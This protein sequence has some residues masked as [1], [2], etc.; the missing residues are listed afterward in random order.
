MKRI[1]K[2]FT[3]LVLVIVLG[4]LTAVVVVRLTVTRE[5]VIVPDLIG[6][7]LVAALDSLE[8]ARPK[9]QGC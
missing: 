1:M 6:K 7:D 9:P 4:A 8:Q 3:A 5:G 2:L